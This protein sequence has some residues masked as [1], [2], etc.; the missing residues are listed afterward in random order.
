MI[1]R[2][3]IVQVVDVH[4]SGMKA[5]EMGE[6]PPHVASLDELDTFVGEWIM[7]TSLAPDPADALCARTS[8]EWLS[9]KRFLV[10]RWEVEHADAPDGIAIIGLNATGAGY[11]QHYF[12]SRGV[13]R[14]YEMIVAD[15]VWT[16][17]RH[18]AAPDFS[19]R[20]TGT[21]DR[22]RNAIVGRWESSSDSSGWKPDFDLAY[23]R[24]H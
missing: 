16:L 20:F 7:T 4:E 14:V 1:S 24:T 3:A 17:E 12:D 23:M 11:L 5:T 21:F 8:F 22:G 10:Q 9:G 13:A 18:A 19:Q 2:V 15:N 6:A